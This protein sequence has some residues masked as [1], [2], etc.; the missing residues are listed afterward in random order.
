M[1]LLLILMLLAAALV[2][3]CTGVPATAPGD[4]V[5]GDVAPDARLDGEDPEARG[6]ASDLVPLNSV[7]TRKVALMVDALDRAET[8]EKRSKITGRLIQLGPRYLK[9]LRSIDR[10]EIALDLFHIVTRIEA[11]HPEYVAGTAAEAPR[12]PRRA[13]GEPS[14]NLPNAP[15]YLDDPGEFDRAEV[16]VF[17]A[18]R[19]A[20][21]RRILASGDTGRAE[22]IAR[23]ALTLLPNTRRRSEFESLIREAKGLGQAAS[24][25]AGTLSLSPASLQ[26]AARRK[27]AKFTG[28]L[29]IRCYLKNVSRSEITL[30]LFEGEGR[31]SLLEL[32][33]RY[34]QLDYQGN[35]LSQNGRELLHVDAGKSVVLQPNE[36]YEIA[37]PLTGLT[38]L[39]QDAPLKY[40]MGLLT[41]KA[42]LRVYG[43][44]D[45]EGK[46]IILRPIA[47]SSESVKVFPFGFKLKTS[48]SRPIN[49]LA[50][51]INRNAPQ[52]LYMA[53]YLVKKKHIRAAGDLL[54][55]TDLETSG[56]AMQRARLKAITLI[57]GTGATY[58]ASEWHSWWQE[59]R[60]RY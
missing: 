15:S 21:A 26:Y 25:I 58:D 34:E 57:T 17:L 60:L 22:K 1:R 27:G 33:L 37:V 12:G 40:A 20:Q 32:H 31:E 5:A 8:P 48:E 7:E 13:G 55:G 38:T 35:V 45:A 49:A 56:L 53:A 10:D 52:D 28:E 9:F 47:F 54:L 3:S 16:E 36:T 18:H 23:A 39:D 6:T 4:F 11:A 43:A 42:S 29:Q 50:T 24:L 51:A 2:A 14:V 46:P 44:L 59:N 19:L 41:I 30:K